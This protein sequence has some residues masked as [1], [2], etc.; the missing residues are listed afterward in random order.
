MARTPLAT[1]FNRPIRDKPNVAYGFPAD[2]DASFTFSSTDDA[3][4]FL[5]MYVS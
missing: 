5:G 2:G 1:F 3:C 4:L